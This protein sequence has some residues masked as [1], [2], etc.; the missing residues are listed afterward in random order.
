MSSR[1]ILR[2][3][4]QALSMLPLITCLFQMQT[5]FADPPLFDGKS[6]TTAGQQCLNPKDGAVAARA[7]RS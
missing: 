6:G 1:F 2:H 7:I 4:W 5:V 3:L